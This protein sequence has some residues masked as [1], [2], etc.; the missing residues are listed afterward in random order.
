MMRMEE[1]QVVH[2][3]GPTQGIK[4]TCYNTMATLV[5][6]KGVTNGW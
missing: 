1:H 6:Q 2:L 5:F 4:V 3:T